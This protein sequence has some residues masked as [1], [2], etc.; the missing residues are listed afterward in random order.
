MTIEPGTLYV[1]SKDDAIRLAD[2]LLVDDQTIS[3]DLLAYLDE[4]GVDLT[5]YT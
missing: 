2:A 5:P 3:V 4:L 1:R